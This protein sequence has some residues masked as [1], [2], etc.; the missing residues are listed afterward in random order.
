MNPVKPAKTKPA[1]LDLLPD[2][3][4]RPLLKLLFIA[5]P[6]LYRKFDARYSLQ[7]SAESDLCKNFIS[8][9]SIKRILTL[10]LPQPM[11]VQG[12][13]EFIDSKYISEY[14]NPT[15]LQAL[16]NLMNIHGSD[17]S[18][19]NNYVDYYQPLL[20]RILSINSSCV[21]A[22]IGIGTNNIH[23]RSN[24]GLWGVP[25]A[26]AKAFRDYS[27][28]IR[29]LA[30]DVDRSIL[31][32]DDR[33]ESMHVDQ[34]SLDSL[35]EF[36][37]RKDWDIVIDDGLHTPLS[38]INFVSQALSSDLFANNR[39]RWIVIEDISLSEGDFWACISSLISLR[40]ENWLITSKS[41]IMLIIRIHPH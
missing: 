3:I 35:S 11:H 33:I 34:L 13:S 38:N 7:G 16:S 17:K 8:K 25:G 41:A 22:E 24:M 21:I 20:D 36:F 23:I 32:Q 1:A 39:E 37:H 15:N 10:T 4:R 14:I 40:F 9:S 31:F 19:T 2:L 5:F 30:G 6:G 27:C 18:S 28:H 26:S 29:V 12:E